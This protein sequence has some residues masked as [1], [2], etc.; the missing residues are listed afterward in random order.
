MTVVLLIRLM[1]MQAAYG[2]E[3]MLGIALIRPNEG[4]TVFTNSANKH[5]V[6]SLSVPG[7]AGA[8]LVGTTCAG[9]KH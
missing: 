8:E 2:I 6:T 7:A 3:S 5:T 4:S 9:A 1:R